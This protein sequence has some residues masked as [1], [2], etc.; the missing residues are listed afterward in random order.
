MKA[1][2]PEAPKVGKYIFQRL[3][4]DITVVPVT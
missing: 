4:I 2:L 1:I 3:P